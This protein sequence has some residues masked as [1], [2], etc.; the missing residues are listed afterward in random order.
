MTSTP[1][2]KIELA[3]SSWSW[4]APY[5]DGKLSL[6]HVPAAAAG[7]GFSKVELND[8]MLP[9]PRFSRV[10]RPFLMVLGT[11]VDLWSYT[12]ANLQR[13]KT[14]LDAARVQCVV[15]TVNTDLTLPQW[16]WPWQAHYIQKGI[17]AA[18]LL[19]AGVY[20]II[21][22]GRAGMEE[23]VDETVAGR[24]AWLV[25]SCPDLRVVVENHWGLSTDINRLLK[26]IAL[27]KSRL[28]VASAGR[29]G[30]TFDPDNLP[31][32]NREPH[33]RALINAAHHVHFKTF[34]FTPEG[35]ETTLPYHLFFQWLK[36]VQYPGFATLEFEGDG[37]PNIGIE[38][39]IALFQRL[40]P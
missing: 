31:K 34:N 37:D 19:G 32:D 40:N 6:L 39:S 15:W 10:R 4:H 5:Q 25:E 17:W 38:R 35:D 36:E 28:P 18:R 3:I 29:L 7:H 24:L 9:P 27:T 12:N 23:A 1:P 13:L 26:V 2:S 21:L 22:G 30:I 33:W 16:R 8:F 14:A 20:R 11:P